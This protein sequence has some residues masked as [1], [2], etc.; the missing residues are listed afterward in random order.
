MSSPLT[1]TQAHAH[2]Y[3]VVTSSHLPGWKQNR[4]AW[5]AL[6]QHLFETLPEVGTVE[7]FETFAANFGAL[8][9]PWPVALNNPQ[10]LRYRYQQANELFAAWKTV[11]PNAGQ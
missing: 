10:G 11:F 3:C 4:E 5:A 6:Q 1:F 2:V 7:Q 9:D 8:L